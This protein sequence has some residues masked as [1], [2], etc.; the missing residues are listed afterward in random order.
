MQDLRFDWDPAKATANVRKHGVT[1]EEAATV[2]SDELALVIDDP[3]HSS[4]EDRFVLLGV[5]AVSRILVV[6]HAFRSSVDVVRIISARKATKPE[7]TTYLKRG[8]R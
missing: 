4:E 6:V 7:R 2:F 5:S 1:F 8:Q 3:D